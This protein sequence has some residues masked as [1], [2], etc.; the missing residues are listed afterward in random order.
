MN[1][2]LVLAGVAAL[3]FVGTAAKAQDSAE[4]EVRK[5]M[6]DNFAAIIHKDAD[7]LSRQYT[8][9]HYR[10]GETGKVSGK[11][12][13]IANAT[14]PNYETSKLEASDVKIRV[15]GNVA[16]VTALITGTGAPKERHRLSTLPD[17]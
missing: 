9:D 11:S 8:D 1:T 2:R 14:N 5:A 13:F 15:Y 12:E 16:V 4:K 17:R 7:A 3:L 10:I 6:D